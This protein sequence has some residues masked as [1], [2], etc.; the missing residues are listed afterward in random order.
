MEGDFLY[1]DID[2]SSKLW[3]TKEKGLIGG[4]NMATSS[5]LKDFHTTPERFDWLVDFIEENYQY[6]PPNDKDKVIIDEG[7][8]ALD[9]YV[10]NFIKKG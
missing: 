6:Q 1:T 3:Y 5:I 9:K 8:N 10:E 2:F 4:M 7:L